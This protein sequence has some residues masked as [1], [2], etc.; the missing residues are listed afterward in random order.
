VHGPPIYPSLCSR[1][2]DVVQET[3]Y[4]SSGMSALAALMTSLL[5]MNGSAEVLAPPGFYSE[6]RE[7]L[8]SFGARVRI[9]PLEAARSPRRSTTSVA[10]IVLLDS[11]VAAAFFGPLRMPVHDIDLVIFDTTCYWLSSARIQRVTN[12]AVQSKLPLALVRSHTK[13]DCLGVEYGRLGSV[14]VAVSRKE[15]PPRRLDWTGDLAAETRNSVR[16]L[17]MAPVP[18]S[19]PPFAGTRQFEHCS[20]ARVAAIIRNNR[21]L[22]QVLSAKLGRSSTSTPMT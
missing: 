17:G 16:L 3:I 19:F 13:L 10:R 8:E 5:R 18:A 20:V 1:T 2:A 4:T 22:A 6:T 14:V 21:R 15:I 7:L 12:W 11:S 9:L